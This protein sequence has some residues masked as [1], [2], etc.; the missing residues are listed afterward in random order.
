ML[1]TKR[2]WRRRDQRGAV[3]VWASMAMVAFI[4]F[5]GIGVDFAGHARA[6]QDA[7][8][9]A[10]EA[11][12]AGGQ[13]L[14]V[15]SGRAYPDGP[16]AAAAASQFIDSAG[17]SGTTEIQGNGIQVSISGA[18]ETQFLSIIGINSLPVNATAVAEVKTTTDGEE[19]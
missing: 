8:A 10:A 12:R 6:S 3:A 14:E 13:F 2:S 9:V 18:Y 15:S 19:R 7:R 4:I 1:S 5:M 11:A 16:Q 17:Y